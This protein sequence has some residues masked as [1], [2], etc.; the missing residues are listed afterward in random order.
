MDDLEEDKEFR[1]NINIYKS[2]NIVPSDADDMEDA[3]VPRITLEEM[4]E[5][6]SINDIIENDVNMS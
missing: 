1:Q 5:D 2:E 4:L 3:E 6:L